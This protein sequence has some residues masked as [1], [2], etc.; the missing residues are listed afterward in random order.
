MRA[1]LGSWA[2]NGSG[3]LG[4]RR[5]AGAFRRVSNAPIIGPGD[6]LHKRTQQRASEAPLAGGR[7]NPAAFVP[8]YGASGVVSRICSVG[9]QMPTP[10]RAQNEGLGVGIQAESGGLAAGQ[11]GGAC[12][13]RSPRPFSP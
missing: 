1:D 3:R 2:W 13:T 11:V 4:R 7:L 9:Y 12:V 5:W 6:H 8:H 10:L